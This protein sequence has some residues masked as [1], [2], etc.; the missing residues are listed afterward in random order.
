MSTKESRLAYEA[1]SVKIDEARGK[2][3]LRKLAELSDIEVGYLSRLKRGERP[4]TV[5]RICALSTALNVPPSELLPD[6]WVTRSAGVTIADVARVSQA[7]LEG[8]KETV[9]IVGKEYAT[10]EQLSRMIC[11]YLE[12]EMTDISPTSVRSGLRLMLK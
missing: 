9:A 11:I 3:S 10:P 12:E 7:V 1:L 4:L 2:M 5:E 6:E 8:Y